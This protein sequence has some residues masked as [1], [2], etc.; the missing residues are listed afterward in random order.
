MIPTF[1]ISEVSK[2]TGLSYD[3][4]RYYE[5]IGLIPPT[6]RKKNG[7]LEFQ[8]LDV[9]RLVFINCLKRTD[10]PLK[11]I[12][13]YMTLINEQDL[14]SCYAIL[15]KHKQH[16]ESQIAE[17]NETLK[18]INFKLENFKELKINGALEAVAR[19]NT[20]DVDVLQ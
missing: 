12:H 4:I 11:E 15:N 1:A 16:I 3:T 6:K 13:R 2:K 19:L 5:K 8:K 20:N 14:D 9:E 17:T 10:M 18:M 7:Q